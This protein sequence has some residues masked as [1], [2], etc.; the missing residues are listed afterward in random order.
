[1]SRAALMLPGDRARGDVRPGRAVIAGTAGLLWLMVQGAVLPQLGLG[2]LP[3]DPLLPLVAAFA[4]GGR[5]AEAWVLAL[6]LGYLADFFGGAS[7][8][9]TMLRYALVVC[10]ALPLH[11]RVVL[12]DR[13][14]PVL[15]VGV[16]TALAG[17]GLLIMLTLMGAENSADWAKLPAESVGTSAAAFLC[18]PLYRRI[19][20]WEDDRARRTT[21][22][23]S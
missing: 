10:I 14:V 8:G 3:F 23:L 5:R 6:T 2:E 16:F 22:A 18:W 21:R 1:M 13:L 11:G 9:R 20:G 17:T 12:R 15:G 4:L 7:S 19:A